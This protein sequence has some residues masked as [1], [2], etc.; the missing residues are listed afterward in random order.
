MY[1]KVERTWLTDRDGHSQQRTDRLPHMVSAESAEGA[2]MAFVSGDH[3]NL[4]GPIG[5]IAGDK[6]TATAVDRGRVYVV[7]VERAS[8]SLADHRFATGSAR[9]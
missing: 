6:A 2:A 1:Y 9:L 5:R 3:A 8:D 4:L 7:F